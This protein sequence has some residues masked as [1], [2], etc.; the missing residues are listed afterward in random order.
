VTKLL[1][2]VG[3]EVLTAVFMKSFV[4]WDLMTYNPLKVNQHFGR[5][6]LFHR[7]GPRITQARNEH[8]AGSKQ[9]LIQGTCFFFETS[10]D[11]QRITRLYIPEYE[12]LNRLLMIPVLS[13]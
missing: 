11:F 1:T 8:E 7:Q 13:L 12:T 10:V 5:T 9:S 3:F 2:Y 4:F 6:C